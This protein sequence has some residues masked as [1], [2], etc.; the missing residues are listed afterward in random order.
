MT[1]TITIPIDF[2]GFWG[3]CGIFLLGFIMGLLFVDD[4]VER[5]EK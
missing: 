2:L 3:A 5:S 4:Q 1:F